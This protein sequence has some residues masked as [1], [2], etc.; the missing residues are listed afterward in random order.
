MELENVFNEFN[1]FY[2]TEINDKLK[3]AK[4]IVIFGAGILGNKV[5]MHLKKLNFNIFCFADN[6]K[7]L[8]GQYIDEIPILSLSEAS[9]KFQMS[10]CIIAI[11]NPLYHFDIVKMQLSDLNFY[12]VVHSAQV[13]QLYSE[14]L[15][16]HYHFAT[17]DFYFENKEQICKVYELLEDNE[18]KKQY[19]DQ[20]K[21]RLTI[22][23]DSLPTPDTKNQYFPSEII[24]LNSNEVFLDAG[25]YDGDTFI[26]FSA[27]V[28]NKFDKYIALEP[29]PKNFDLI[30][31][32][33]KNTENLIIDQ[34]AIGA[35]NEF[36][37]FNSTG[38]EGAS[39]NNEGNIRVECV[40]I[41]EKYKMYKPTFLKFDI[42]GA[43]LDALNGALNVIKEYTPKIA[44]C[45]YHKPQDI[46]E[47]PLWI[48]EVNSNYSFYVRTHGSDG[49][50]F[51]LYAIPKNK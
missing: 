17:P 13:M 42:E 7:Q 34:Y 18:S 23:F 50:E 2:L 33:L 48:N 14:N 19:L 10:T 36:L 46:F 12:N 32:N 43:E 11:W 16:P 44:V 41:D 37:N 40:S 8:W 51:V 49:F 45:I 47:I 39:I 22:D 3:N 6:N 27:R 26:E 25:A 4:G 15:L 29:D 1:E 20:L 28:D 31:L 30:K 35:K 24:I 5:A 9:V 38:G 21:Y